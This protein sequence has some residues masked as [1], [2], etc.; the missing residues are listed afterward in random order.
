MSVRCFNV[1]KIMKGKLKHHIFPITCSFVMISRRRTVLVCVCHVRF[2]L[3]SLYTSLHILYEY[4]WLLSLLC[5]SPSIHYS[6]MF[7]VY[8]VASLNNVYLSQNTYPTDPTE[9][10]TKLTW[11][12]EKIRQREYCNPMQL[13]LDWSLP[14]AAC[15]NVLLTS[16]QAPRIAPNPLV[17]KM[18]NEIFSFFQC[19]RIFFGNFLNVEHMR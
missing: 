9:P 18:R 6:Y 13:S 3:F 7:L 14:T 16:F 8:A 12:Y 2:S 15:K 10:K 5:T 17:T 19:C 11:K 4:M 1:T